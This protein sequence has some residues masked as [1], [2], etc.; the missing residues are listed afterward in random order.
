MLWVLN[1]AY[2]SL[3]SIVFL[4]GLTPLTVYRELCALV[5]QLSIFGESR[6]PPKLPE[7]DHNNLGPCFDTVIR[8]IEMLM[9]PLGPRAFEKRYFEREGDHLQVALEPAWLS[10]TKKLYLGVE[11]AMEHEDCVRL[12]LSTQTRRSL[13]DIKMGSA[14]RVLQIFKQ[15]LRGLTLVPITMPPKELPLGPAIVY[16]EIERDNVFWRDVADSATLAVKLNP[17]HA[18]F[19]DGQTV[20][21]M[22][23]GSPDLREIKFA[24]FVI[25]R[26]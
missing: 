24:L 8:H 5:G 11:T 20:T 23:P 9:R 14:G 21:V 7:Y 6:R 13:L 10:P 1:A 16:F 3:Q 17:Q 18:Q 22:L 25:D 26:K 2:S 15:K 12:L 4:K 19:K